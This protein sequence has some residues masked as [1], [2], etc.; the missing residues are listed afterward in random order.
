MHQVCLHR[1]SSVKW[2]FEC[3]TLRPQDRDLSTNP[4]RPPGSDWR[5]A[6]RN[7]KGIIIVRM[8]R[9]ARM[10]SWYESNRTCLEYR[11]LTSNTT[12]IIFLKFQR[13]RK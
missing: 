9:E 1:G 6:F 13:G 5:D 4:P 2:G 8:G 10:F 11:R 12:C 7:N 3:G